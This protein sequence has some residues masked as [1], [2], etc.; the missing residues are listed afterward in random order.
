MQCYTY[1]EQEKDVNRKTGKI[2]IKSVV[3][4][5]VNFLILITALWLWKMLK[6]RKLDKGYT[7]TLYHFAI[8]SPKLFQNT[9]LK[10]ILKKFREPLR[11]FGREI[12][13]TI[14]NFRKITLGATWRR[15]CLSVL[16][17]LFPVL[18][19]WSWILH[20]FLLYLLTWC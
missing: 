19:Y 15:Y 9:K 16:R 1:S 20:T 13:R 18:W 3:Y 14:L 5:S 17:Y 11:H 10:T 8:L 6:F 2:R 4:P 7:R 12:F